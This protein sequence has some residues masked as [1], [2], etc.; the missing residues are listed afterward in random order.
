MSARIPPTLLGLLL[1]T[2]VLLGQDAK[3]AQPAGPEPKPATPE[4]MKRWVEQLGDFHFDVRQQASD[5]LATAGLAALPYLQEATTS[6]DP[7]V[8]RR[9]WWI[10]DGWAGEGKVPAIL[11]KLS[12]QSAPVRAAAADQLGKMGA[13]AKEA[14]P[15]LT[16]VTNKDSSE[17]VRTCAREA[18]KVIQA[19]A[20]LKLAVA[21]IDC[22]AAAGKEVR[23]RIEIAN[24]GTASATTARIMVT[25]PEQIEVTRVDGPN[26]RQDGQRIVSIP[27]T[28]DPGAR[29]QWDIVGKALK[30]GEVPVTV[31][32]LADQLANPLSETKKSLIVEAAKDTDK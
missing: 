6:S 19:S 14:I 21:D 30:A 3:P 12:D 8:V 20:E 27:Q 11:F 23:Y 2:S 7:E 29:L 16:A 4:Q 10:I 24:V 22:P 26:F 5:K 28:L 1:I 9:A 32:L 18:L 25:M 31:E 17:I 13:R 15:A